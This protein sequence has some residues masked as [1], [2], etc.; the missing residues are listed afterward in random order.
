MPQL[1]VI[2]PTH[3][4]AD[5][6][7]ECLRNLERQTI[8][9]N[10]EVIVINDGRDDKTEALFA[11]SSWQ[12]PVQFFAVEKSQQGVARNEGVR[13]ARSNTVLFIGDD[14]FLAP[15]ACEKHVAAHERLAWQET[16]AVLGYTTWDPACG[17]TPVMRWL[18]TSGWQFG[19]PL[20]QPYA[21]AL[22]PAELQHR[23]TYTSH[24]SLPLAVAKKFLFRTDV[25]LYG[26]EDVEWGMRLRDAGV[27]LFYEPD[28]ASLHHHH[29]DLADSLKR[30]EILGRS[31]K[32]IAGKVPAFDRVPRGWKLFAY[33]VL[34]LLPTMAGKHR[35]AF[36]QGLT[37]S[38]L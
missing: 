4:R 19:Y 20:L 38:K 28:A 15:D 6:L 30:M 14:I 37:S 35:K 27:R 32:D 21:H 25:H 23:V 31:A 1:S 24:I 3:K 13:S 29:L 18:E 17:I 2:I 22:V 8:A 5:I 12:M 26:W 10:I 9:K 34:A 36:L 33:R 16:L 11:K 7:E